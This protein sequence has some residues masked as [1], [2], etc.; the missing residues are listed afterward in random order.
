MYEKDR[1]DTGTRLQIFQLK[2]FM[3]L[4]ITKKVNNLRK[5]NGVTVL[6]RVL[7][8]VFCIEVWCFRERFV[9]L[10]HILKWQKVWFLFYD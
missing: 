3:L 10:H 6:G 4:N 9:I 8:G 7:E 2:F 5:V 1:K